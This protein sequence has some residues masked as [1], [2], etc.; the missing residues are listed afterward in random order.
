MENTEEIWK[1]IEGYEGYYQA[2]N[3]GRTRS[4]NRIIVEANTGMLR[5]KKGRVLKNSATRGY[6]IVGLHKNNKLKMARVCRIVY[7][8]FNPLADKNLDI[9]HIDGNKKNDNL[10]NLELVTK[11]QN[12]IHAY[13]I[14]LC[15][16]KIGKDVHS[17]KKVKCILTN[18][19]YD[20]IKDASKDTNYSDSHLSRMLNGEYKNKTTMILYEE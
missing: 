18:R 14:G 6:N 12:M 1:D 5:K 7:F 2:S 8:S 17:S 20:T 4:L 10:E 19:I 3:K 13:K 15:T 9:N 16:I 11:S